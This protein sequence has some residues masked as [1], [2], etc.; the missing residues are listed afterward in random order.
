MTAIREAF[1]RAVQEHGAWLPEGV[2]LDLVL[3]SPAAD[4]LPAT[5]AEEMEVLTFGGATG[6]KYRSADVKTALG[7]T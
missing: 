1:D 5:S 2:F 7:F 6:T 4:R 3:A